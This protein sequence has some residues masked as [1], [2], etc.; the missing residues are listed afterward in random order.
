MLCGAADNGGMAATGTRPKV[1]PVSSQGCKNS[2]RGAVEI[3]AACDETARRRGK[4]K[5]ENH[6]EQRAADGTQ[7]ED[8]TAVALCGLEHGL[9]AAARSRL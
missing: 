8:S 3:V 9:V 1:C 5:S 7:Q 4:K 6:A 2:G